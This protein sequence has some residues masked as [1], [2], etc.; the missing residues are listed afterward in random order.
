M[1]S[2]GGKQ[3]LVLAVCAASDIFF[4]SKT[5]PPSHIQDTTPLREM[6]TSGYN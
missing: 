1:A 5:A 2:E 6:Y 4:V 3:W